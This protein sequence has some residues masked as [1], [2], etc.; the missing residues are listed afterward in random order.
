MLHY[1]F[2]HD[3]NYVRFVL[4]LAMLPALLLTVTFVILLGWAAGLV[5]ALLPAFVLGVWGY[6]WFNKKTAKT[7]AR[8]RLINDGWLEV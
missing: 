6:S 7:R 1:T 8:N 3:H 2:K 4:F 5:G